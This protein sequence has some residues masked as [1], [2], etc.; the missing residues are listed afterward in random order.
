VAERLTITG[1]A[2]QLL[3]APL[4]DPPR[5]HPLWRAV[6][7]W[8][9]NPG[10]ALL[11][12]L[13]ASVINGV[14]YSGPVVDLGCGGGAFASLLLHSPDIGIDRDEPRCLAAEARGTYTS[15]LCGD[16]HH[17]PVLSASCR[18][19]IANSVLEHVEDW[20]SAVGE[21]HRILIEG[22]RLLLTVPTARKRPALFFSR[23]DL[24]ASPEI[25]ERYWMYFDR[26][27]GHQHYADLAEWSMTLEHVGFIVIA[28]RPYEGALAGVIDLLMNIRL[29]F[30]EWSQEPDVL[31]SRVWP[32]VLFS[33]LLPFYEETGGTLDTGIFIAA[34]KRKA[35]AKTF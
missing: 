1:I 21:C 26:R 18:T 32:K 24:Y 12:A 11:R 14:D 22:G 31:A 5:S 2:R 23:T 3:A 25:A 7:I 13:E 17:L 30:V 4:A 29:T 19:V 27:W 28:A 20:Q 34:E 10:L 16:L 6:N 35:T 8:P 15:V 9:Q 33:L